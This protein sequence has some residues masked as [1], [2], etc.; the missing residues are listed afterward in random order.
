M[1]FSEKITNWY[2][3]NKRDL[4]WRH[5]TDPY[6]I[7]LSEII[8]QQTRIDQGMTYYHRFTDTYPDIESLASAS[9]E[10]VLKLWQGLGYY[11]R[12]RNLHRTAKIIA[13]DFDGEFP[14]HYKNILALPGIGKYT[15]AAISSIAFNQPFPV[16]D[17]NVYRVLTR[18]FGIREPIDSAQGNKLVE[19][20]AREIMDHSDP[21]SYNQAVMEFGALYCKP[22]NPDCKNCIF[23]SECLAFKRNEVEILPVKKSRSPQRLRHF[24]YLIFCFQGNDS[25]KILINKRGGEDI[26]KNMYDFPLIES[27]KKI[28]LKQIKEMGYNGIMLKNKPLKTMGNET[29]HILSHQVI[30]ARFMRLEF[31]ENQL[32]EVLKE[33]RNE[34]LIPVSMEE[35]VRFPVPRLIENFL[36]E[37][38]F[39]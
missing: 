2:T 19:N 31:P 29:K 38:R 33:L 39:I 26:W 37:N 3:I 12:A 34:N 21:G 23:S 35:L 30:T 11:T 24:Y 9:E 27:V 25:S 6:K 10:K 22:N 36:K 5:T 8:F 7:W 16:I 1:N 13:N 20:K 18:V 14:G 4:P 28:S 15:A 32:S 17:G